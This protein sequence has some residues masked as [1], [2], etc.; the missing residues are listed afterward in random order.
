MSRGERGKPTL[1]TCFEARTCIAGH[2][3]N[4]RGDGSTPSAVALAEL[5]CKT[6]VEDGVAALPD[7]SSTVIT[8]RRV[9]VRYRFRWSGRARQESPDRQP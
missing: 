1:G 8:S 5:C 4:M 6:L 3:K 7:G 2:V 9:A